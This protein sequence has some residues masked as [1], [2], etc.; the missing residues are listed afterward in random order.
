MDSSKLACYINNTNTIGKYILDNSDCS[1]LSD[2]AITALSDTKVIID[3]L[4]TIIISVSVLIV[5]TV[6]LAVFI[7]YRYCGASTEQR[8]SVCL[9]ILINPE[10]FTLLISSLRFKK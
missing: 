2:T 9:I 1:S 10:D 3:F 4:P 5:I 7:Y 8:D 6:A